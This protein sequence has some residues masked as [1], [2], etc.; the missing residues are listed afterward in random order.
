MLDDDALP[1]L[2]EH[3]DGRGTDL[4]GVPV[5]HR[6]H[7]RPGHRPRDSMDDFVGKCFRPPLRPDQRHI[8]MP[9][10]VV[11][12]GNIHPTENGDALIHNKVLAV[13]RISR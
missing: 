2:V 13:I 4:C 8:V 12:I 1:R 10:P 3:F 5:I 7:G 6:N 9:L 11:L